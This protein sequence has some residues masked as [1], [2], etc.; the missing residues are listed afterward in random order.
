[1]DSTT[2][3][4]TKRQQRQR[5]R[6]RAAFMDGAESGMLEARGTPLTPEERAAAE[7]IADEP[8]GE[9]QVAEAERAI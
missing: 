9:P 8:Y 1:M 6:M 3:Q 5:E 7:A 4:E 2:I